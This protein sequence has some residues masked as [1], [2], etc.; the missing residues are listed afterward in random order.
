[1]HFVQC[2]GAKCAVA[3]DWS[4]LNEDD[5]LLVQVTNEQSTVNFSTLVPSRRVGDYSVEGVIVG[6]E[7][8]W[9]RATPRPSRFTMG[10]LLPV[11]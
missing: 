2:I 5:L 7:R 1:M 9:T 6:D 8:A 11:A 4:M 10:A 3:A